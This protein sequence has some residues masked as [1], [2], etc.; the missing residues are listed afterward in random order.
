[1]VETHIYNSIM[2]LYHGTG[3]KCSLTRYYH[4]PPYFVFYNYT[5]RITYSLRN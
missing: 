3:N 2:I 4:T 1:M 5:L